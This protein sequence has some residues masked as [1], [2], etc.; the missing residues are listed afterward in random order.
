MTQKVIPNRVMA[1]KARLYQQR[2][3]VRAWLFIVVVKEE[4]ELA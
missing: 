1:T 2:S 4:E 3:Q